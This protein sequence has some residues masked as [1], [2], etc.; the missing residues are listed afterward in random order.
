MRRDLTGCRILITGASRGIGRCLALQLSPWRVQLT[1]AARSAEALNALADEARILGATA[2]AKATDVTVADEREALIKTAVE[3]MGGL[4][5]LINNA[6]V[7]SFGHFDTSSEA[8]L[9]TIMEVNFFAPAEMMRIAVPHLIKGRNAAIV[10]VASICGR[11]GLPGWS[12]HCASKFALVGLSEALRGEFA[13]FDVDVLVVLP[14]LVRSDD[15]GRHLLRNEGRMKLNFAGAQPPEEVAAEIIGALQRS[16]AETPVGWQARWLRRAQ[17]FAPR[18]VDRMLAR[19]VRELY[20]EETK[21]W[22]L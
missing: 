20:P 12:E 5:L 17:R 3:S 16:R 10:N 6:G 8:V 1:L 15:L 9:R 7:A 11:V 19:K 13:R 2:F 14:G 21:Q 4:D 18:F 22:D